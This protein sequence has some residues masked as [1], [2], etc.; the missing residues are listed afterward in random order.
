M[1][2]RPAAGWR[3]TSIW[4][5]V[6]G[7]CCGSSTTIDGLFRHLDGAMTS[8]DSAAA[9]TALQGIVDLAKSSPLA[10]MGDLTQVRR[11]LDDPDHVWEL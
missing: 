3:A 10:A 9:A 5:I 2:R 11:A 6:W 4:R 8:G 7:A 1:P